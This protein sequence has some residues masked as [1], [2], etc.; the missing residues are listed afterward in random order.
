MDVALIAPTGHYQP[1][2]WI[3][4]HLSYLVPRRHCDALSPHVAR[5]PREDHHQMQ[6]GHA[7]TLG[8]VKDLAARHGQLRPVMA[9]CMADFDIFDS[10]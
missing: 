6:L 4:F 5:V 1:V 7:A 8:A 10:V 2:V 3:C 9:S